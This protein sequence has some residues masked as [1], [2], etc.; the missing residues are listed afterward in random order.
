MKAVL[1]I[2][3]MPKC[4]DDC[5]LNYD[6]GF[7]CDGFALDDYTP[8]DMKE[9]RDETKRPSWCPLIEIPD[10]AEEL[11]EQV[12]R[13]VKEYLSSVWDSIKEAEK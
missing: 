4:C 3:E 11:D 1:V 10:N 13:L 9:M 5:Q 7:G 12:K 8:I 6:M 2:N